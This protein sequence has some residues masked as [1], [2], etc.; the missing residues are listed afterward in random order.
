[1]LPSWADANLQQRLTRDLRQRGIEVGTN[2]LAES[3]PSNEAGWWEENDMLR[4]Y[5][6]EMSRI[7]LL[8]A[9]EEKELARR[10]QQGRAAQ[11][12]LSH[13]N[14]SLHSAEKR[15]L[16]ALVEDGLQ[17]RDHLIRANT[18]LVVSC[19]KKYIG[20]GVPLLDLIQEG[21]LG[22]MKAVEK[23]DVERGFRFS[24]YAT[25]W[26]RQMISRAVYNQAR[27][28][29]LPVHI[30]D[31]LRKIY[32]SIG[33]L[34]QR[35]G[36][37]PSRAELAEEL[38]WDIARIE[39]TLHSAVFPLS[40]DEPVGEDEENE[41]GMFIGDEHSQGPVQSVYLNVMRE[42]IQKLLDT[43]PAREALILRLRYGLWDG[44]FY[45]LE[46]VGQKF[47]L[48]RERIRQIEMQALR[49]LR[50]PCCARRLKEYLG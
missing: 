42:E 13:G 43:L 16:E 2:E 27:T 46:E 17:A 32:R 25:W 20:H 50:Q 5:L 19:A 30:G 36:R 31:R 40:L 35:L 23:Y 45:T 4:M 48:T 7:P 38:D 11:Q 34:E 3:L 21:N 18:R 10:V 29:R 15:R 8:S 14:F 22:L 1:M 37:P 6:D 47:G 39:Q 49:R 41:L 28:I 26:I 44:V 12:R 9:E 24:T 33:L